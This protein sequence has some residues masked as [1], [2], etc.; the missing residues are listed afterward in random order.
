[1]NILDTLSLIEKNSL[2]IVQ[3]K[4]DETIFSEGEKC[5]YIGIVLLGE[6][7]IS[8]FSYIGK[9]I[10]FNIIKKDE[11]F[12]NNLIFSLN[13]IYRGNVTASKDSKI[14]LI[15]KLDLIK[16]LRN[17]EKF[18]LEFLAL[19]AEFGKSLNSRIKLLALDNAE[20]RL[21]YYLTI[22]NKIIKYD[23]I[24]SLASSLN[25]SR[26]TLSRLI[27]RLVKNRIIEKGK[28]YIKLL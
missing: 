1:M 12:G 2:K 26:E 7:V 27:S 28:H 23:S 17:N 14:A 16:L 19:E 25:L 4:K 9:E 10:I 3:L 8:S 18:L 11:M 21:I 13:P 6:L 24:T 22:N 5:E 20:E 15:N